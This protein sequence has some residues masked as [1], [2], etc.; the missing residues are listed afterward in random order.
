[1]EI[2]QGADPVDEAVVRC[3]RDAERGPPSWL[4]AWL[5]RHPER[6][7]DLA[8]FLADQNEVERQ[9]APLRDL[10]AQEALTTEQGSRP[11]AGAPLC[12]PGYEI[13]GELGRGGM[14]VVY[15]ALQAKAN[16]PVALKT[17]RTGEFA[18]ALEVARFRYE[19]EAAAS[20]DHPHV[21]PIFEVGESGG[22]VFYSM[23]RLSNG[24]LAHRLRQGPRPDPKQTARLLAAVARAVHHAHEHGIIHRDLK[25]ANVLLD[26]HDQP[27]VSDFGLARRVDAAHSIGP[28]GAV[29][30]T[31]EYAAPE[32][33]RG[34]KVDERADVYGLGAI[35]YECLTGQPPFRGGSVL[36][37]MTRVQ[38]ALVVEPHKLAPDVPTDLEGICL[39]CL[40]K[41]P[42][43]RYPSAEAVAVALERFLR[44]ESPHER[45]PVLARLWKAV[46]RPPEVPGLITGPA[47][48]YSAAIT[49]VWHGGVFLLGWFGASLVWV[50]LVFLIGDALACALMWRY[51]VRSPRSLISSQEL[52]SGALHVGII[53]AQLVALAL[54]TLAT[55][56]HLEAPGRD[57]FL[58]FYPALA[59]LAGLNTFAHGI[60][61]SWGMLYPIGL[62]TMVLALPLFLLPQWSPLIYG[63]LQ[64]LVYVASA[65]VL[66]RY[67]PPRHHRAA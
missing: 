41:E 51:H 57:S 23:K 17:I 52:R 13:L 6:A 15:E 47:L 19:A 2:E 39:G 59:L 25:P 34:E 11:S 49:T 42:A 48:W 30:G 44:G 10:F 4:A 38:R 20:L 37:I 26:E 53:A 29:V 5:A 67:I 3:C 33:L 16:R 56:G 18:S 54:A 50:W 61:S 24:S 12:V 40:S 21:V 9:A 46:T 58:W 7:A 8:R 55:P 1:V 45:P 65:L 66:P 63:T 43:E 31:A 35:L 27:H 14:G 62:A 36:E 28:T 22:L 32:Q 60:A 64:A